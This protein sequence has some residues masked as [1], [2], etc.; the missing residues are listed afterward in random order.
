M[1]YH[2]QVKDNK[3]KLT[4]IKLRRG[5]H[6]IRNI[7][8]RLDIPKSTLSGWFR[9][10]KLTPKQKNKLLRDWQNAL[11]KA[12]AKAVVWHNAQKRKRLDEAKKQ[13]DDV[14][15][16]LN[17]KN[18]RLID[19]ALAMLYL[20]E[21]FKKTDVTGMGNTDPLILKTFVTI[22]H[23]NYGIRNDQ[24]QCQLHLRADQEKERLK[25]YWSAEL[26][27]PLKCFTFVYF[28]KRTIGSKTHSDYKGVCMIRCGNVAI[29]RK[30]VN[31]GKSF[32][33]KIINAGV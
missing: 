1:N 33:E 32:C 28:D 4:A 22:L 30:L 6:S 15:K 19:L 23:K 25:K 13:S 18:K 10:I 21:G 20:G 31:L 7:A 17:L 9:N 5:G 24:I 12:R 11:V 2:V 26:K 3:R 16:G 14:I 29:Q 8:K 27:L